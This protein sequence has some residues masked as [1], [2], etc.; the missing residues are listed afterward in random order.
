[1][2]YSRFSFTKFIKH[3]LIL[4]Q[5]ANLQLLETNI[6]LEIKRKAIVSGCDF[7]DKALFYLQHFEDVKSVQ[8]RSYLWPVVSCIRAEYRKIYGPEIT[9]YLHTFHAV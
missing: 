5:L 2:L 3:L 6:R 8:I 4:S 7:S 9:P 1:M